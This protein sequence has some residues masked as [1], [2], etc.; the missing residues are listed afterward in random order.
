MNLQAC[1][2]R[3]RVG[4]HEVMHCLDAACSVSCKVADVMLL[5]LTCWGGVSISST[6]TASAGQD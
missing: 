5:L 3:L 6:I 2:N 1:N 4:M